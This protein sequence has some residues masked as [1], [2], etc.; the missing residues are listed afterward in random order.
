M[1]NHEINKIFE[2]N[3]EMSKLS[4]SITIY[5]TVDHYNIAELFSQ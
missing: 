1:S 2:K 5:P 4:Q 3:K